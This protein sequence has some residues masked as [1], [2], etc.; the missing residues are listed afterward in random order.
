MK[1]SKTLDRFVQRS[2][3]VETTAL[4][5]LA[6][7]RENL[8][9][10]LSEQELERYIYEIISEIPDCQRLHE[11]FYPVIKIFGC[12]IA[13][14]LK[15]VRWKIFGQYYVFTSARYFFFFLDPKRTRRVNIKKVS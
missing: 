4:Q 15:Y 13:D 14:L 11:S 12:Y 5:L 7:A 3:D 6:H 10:F 1:S 2:I 8:S 9:G